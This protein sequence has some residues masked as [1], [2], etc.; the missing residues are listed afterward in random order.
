MDRSKM[1]ALATSIAYVESPSAI[2]FS[3][4]SLSYCFVIHAF[5]LIKCCIVHRAV[6]CN[7]S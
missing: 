6:H 4:V 7:F 2:Y 5:V 3:L 1:L